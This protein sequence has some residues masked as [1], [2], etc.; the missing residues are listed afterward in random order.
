M[1]APSRLTEL[2]PAEFDPEV[3]DLNDLTELEEEYGALDG[4]DWSRFAVIRHLMWCVLRH[5]EPEITLK[6]TG[7][8]FTVANL[9]AAAERVLV[10]SGIKDDGEPQGNPAGAG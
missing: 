4:I 6:E 7:A 1:P 9:T 2:R 5:A 8:R 10:K 3:L